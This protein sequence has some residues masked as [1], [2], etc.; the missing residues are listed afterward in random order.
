MDDTGIG[1]K[2]YILK[3]AFFYAFTV[4]GYIMEADNTLMNAITVKDLARELVDMY[5][6]IIN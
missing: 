5:E 2:R 3:C 4:I 1:L 6:R